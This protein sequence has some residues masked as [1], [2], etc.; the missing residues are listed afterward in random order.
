MHRQNEAQMLPKAL[1][2][3]SIRVDRSRQL[4]L[5]FFRQSTARDARPCWQLF[6]H[7]MPCLMGSIRSHQLT[8]M[9]MA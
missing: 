8:A 5:Q 7:P 2:Q 1:G 6:V 9:Q 4:N 3:D